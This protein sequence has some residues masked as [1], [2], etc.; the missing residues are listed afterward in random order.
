MSPIRIMRGP[1]SCRVYVLG[2]RCHHGLAG[3][4]M[5][6]AGLAAMVHDRRDRWWTRDVKPT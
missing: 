4:L 2:H 6:A 5:M 1:H 3:F